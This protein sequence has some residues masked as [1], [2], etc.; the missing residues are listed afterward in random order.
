[1]DSAAIVVSGLLL[2]VITLSFMLLYTLVALVRG[3]NNLVQRIAGAMSAQEEIDQET[4]G[5]D[6]VTQTSAPELGH[7]GNRIN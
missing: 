2:F 7:R 3:D 5:L 6:V 4:H 1:M